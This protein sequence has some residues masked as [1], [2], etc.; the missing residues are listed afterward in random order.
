[1]EYIYGSLMPVRVL[2]E[3]VFWKKQEREHIEVILAIVPQLEPE[4]VQVLR[5]WEPV[6]TK[7]EE[8]ASAWLQFILSQGGSTPPDTMHKI[9]LLLKASVY[10]SEQ[11]MKH[12]ETMKKYS[13]AVHSVPLAPIVFDHI[14]SESAYFLNVV[15]ALKDKPL[16]SFASPDA[17]GAHAAPPGNAVQPKAF[18]HEVPPLDSDSSSGSPAEAEYPLTACNSEPENTS[19]EPAATAPQSPASGI[20][21]YIGSDQT[22]QTPLTPLTAQAQ[23]AQTVQPAEE[24]EA[25][26]VQEQVEARTAPENVPFGYS[27][28]RE[29]TY[30]P[31]GGWPPG[32]P[33]H[34][35]LMPEYY[36]RGDLASVPIGGHTLP[37]LPY[38]YD[39]LEPYIDETTMRVHHDKH[40][41]SYV[42]GLNRAERA[43]AE[44]R[45]TGR[46]DLV[47][48]WS[49]ELAFNGAGHYLHTIFW[50]TMNPVGG[51]QPTGE[52]LDQ[53]TRDFGSFKAFKMHFSKAAEKVQGGG[54]TILVWSPRSR[55]LEILQAEKH[56]NLSQWDV[57]PLLPIDVWEHAYYLKHKDERAKYIEDWWHV[58]NWPAVDERFQA[59][60]TLAWKPY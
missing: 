27:V 38:P 40:H 24:Q 4:Y 44:A 8:A 32:H 23:S 13:R 51:G 43:L 50:N 45:R 21:A 5:E 17:P 42:D 57:I 6:F 30:A 47:K 56:Q 16:S 10:Q 48:H 31:T 26:P 9:E 22:P 60:R 53:I 25:K 37:P 14:A 39:A 58:V 54:W 7:T 12:L 52:L 36:L 15:H 29:V 41:Q 3:V 1:M 59:A 34:Q 18:I 46:F 55:R 11:F 35:P 20:L 49:N 33:Q 19:H 28:Y 2:E